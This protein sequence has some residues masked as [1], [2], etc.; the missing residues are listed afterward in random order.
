[1]TDTPTYP[2]VDKALVAPAKCLVSGDI[3]GPFVDLGIRIPYVDPYAYLHTSV[4]EQIGLSVDMVPRRE[5]DAIEERLAALEAESAELRE[6]AAAIQGMQ[7]A[8]ARLE[9]VAS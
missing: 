9:A 4:A 5:V 6:F 8:E 3:D 1:M 7:D 2:I